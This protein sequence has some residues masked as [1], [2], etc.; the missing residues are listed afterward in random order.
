MEQRLKTLRGSTVSEE[1]FLSLMA[2]V[3]GALAEVK[4][5]DLQNLSYKQGKLDLDLKLGDLQQLDHLKQQLIAIQ[6]IEV[7]VQSATVKNNKLE[8]RIRIG[9]RI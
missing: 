2:E 1:G 9:R 8:S 6:G 5:L 4:G 7:D 3:G